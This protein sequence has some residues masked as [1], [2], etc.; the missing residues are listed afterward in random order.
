[1]ERKNKSEATEVA[2]LP[3]EPVFRWKVVGGSPFHGNNHRIYKPGEV[4]KATEAEVPL[5]FR[6]VII[7]VDTVS[8]Q[9]QERILPGKVATYEIKEREK[10]DPEDDKEVALYDVVNH[11]G[12]VINEKPLSKK[13]AESFLKDLTE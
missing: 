10:V 3:S 2:D 6:D 9:E 5:A 8:V 4:F 12:K 13:K 1:V 11:K 7:K